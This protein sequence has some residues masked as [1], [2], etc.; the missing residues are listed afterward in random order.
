MFESKL[1]GP[2]HEY[3][4]SHRDS[5]ASHAKSESDVQLKALQAL[6]LTRSSFMGLQRLNTGS[7]LCSLGVL[8][9]RTQHA[10]CL[11]FALAPAA[12]FGQEAGNITLVLRGAMCLG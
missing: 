11:V 9:W 1:T 8:E 10:A 5:H 4:I 3:S 7:C 6:P 2:S 12:A